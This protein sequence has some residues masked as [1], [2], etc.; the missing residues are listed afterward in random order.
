[1]PWPVRVVANAPSL[2]CLAQI[3]PLKIQA[4]EMH[5]HR[6]RLV[7][8]CYFFPAI[9]AN[10]GGGHLKI[11]QFT[12]PIRRCQAEKRL[13]ILHERRQQKT[14]A[15]HRRYQTAAI[16]SPATSENSER[17]TWWPIK[18][19]HNISPQ[20]PR[21]VYSYPDRTAAYRR[22]VDPF[23]ELRH[24]FGNRDQLIVPGRY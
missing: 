20:G 11:S 2:A 13:A 6:R 18:R 12:L 9:S 23:I 24:S 1:M 4:I 22:N 3:L 8:A 15:S 16:R 14:G 19:R 7:L 5:S 21:D 17:D 10:A